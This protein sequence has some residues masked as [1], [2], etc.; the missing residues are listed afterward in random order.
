MKLKYKHTLVACCA[1]YVV[2]AIINNFSPLLY[3]L[4]AAQLGISLSK[5]SVLIT[6]NFTIQICMDLSGTFLIDKIGYRASVIAANCCAVIGFATLGILP[7]LMSDKF[8]ALLISTVICAIGGGLLE[9]VVSPI[10]E[11]MPKEEGFSMSLLH[12]FYCWG[13]AGVILLSTLFFA[14]FDI[15]HWDILA[16]LWCLVPLFSGI[17]FIFVPMR[18]LENDGGTGGSLRYLFARRQF[19]LLMA[20]MLAAGASELGMAQW[21]SYFAEEGL[22]VGKAFGDLLGPCA[23]AIAMALTRLLFGIYGSK[24]K[25][26]KCLAA[27][28]ALCVA[29]YLLASLSP[30]PV[31]SLL[32]CAISGVAVAILWPGSYTL[33]AQIL[34]RGGTPM[35]ALFALSGD[36]GCA[37]GPSLIGLVSDG[38]TGGVIPIQGFFSGTPESAGIKLGILIAVVFPLAAMLVCI[39]LVRF[40]KRQPTKT[41][42]NKQ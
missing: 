13:H 31:L 28:F 22:G 32:G 2:Q 37:L 39:S 20:V 17:L 8:A 18:G 42:E 7:G 23:F 21:A 10:V 3:A 19:W 40:C 6:L 29:A 36:L 26:E 4:F 30:L 33:G 25:I 9:V 1:G 34:P 12:S 15:S 24:L 11:A 16:L 38:V 5:I 14:L 41:Q 35:F 27:S